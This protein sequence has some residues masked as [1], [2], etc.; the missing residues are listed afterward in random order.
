MLLSHVLEHV[1]SD[2]LVRMGLLVS[3]D[4]SHVRAAGPAKLIR[5]YGIPKGVFFVANPFEGMKPFALAGLLPLPR[6]RCV[7]SAVMSSPRYPSSSIVPTLESLVAHSS[8][9]V[10]PNLF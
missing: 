1:L 7:A 9:R 8:T 6:L 10:R 2:F 4:R 5:K 3:L